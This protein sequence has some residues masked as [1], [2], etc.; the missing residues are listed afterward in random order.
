MKTK[1]LLVAKV[2]IRLCRLPKLASDGEGRGGGE[3][4]GRRRRELEREGGREIFVSTEH[5]PNRPESPCLPIYPIQ[6]LP[7]GG[8]IPGS[9]LNVPKKGHGFTAPTKADVCLSVNMSRLLDRGR[10]GSE[11]CVKDSFLS[12]FLVEGFASAP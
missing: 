11:A 2:P 9:L 4:R 10:A 7:I 1:I 6:G 5:P 12:L 3:G 8:P